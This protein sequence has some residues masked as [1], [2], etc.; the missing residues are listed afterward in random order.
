MLRLL[1]Q[2]IQEELRGTLQMGKNAR[3]AF[4][5][6]QANGRLRVFALEEYLSAFARLE[7]LVRF[8]DRAAGQELQ[9]DDLTLSVEDCKDLLTTAFAGTVTFSPVRGL[10]A[11]RALRFFTSNTPKFRSSIRPSSTSVS[12]IPLNT[13]W[14]ICWT[15]SWVRPISSAIALAMSFLVT[16]YSFLATKDRPPLQQA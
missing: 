2:H 9:F 3:L 14:T 12:T 10:R 1:R 4:D 6:A 5:E 7:C 13:R 15:C 11:G 8:L 16:G